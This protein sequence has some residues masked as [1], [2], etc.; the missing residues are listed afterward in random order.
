MKILNILSSIVLA[1]FIISC[2]GK[3]T[4]KALLGKQTPYEKYVQSLR[5]AKLHQ[6]GL[7][8]DWLLAGNKVLQDSL[9]L[10]IPFEET[11]YFQAEKPAAFSYNFKAREGESIRIAA[12]SKAREEVKLFLDLFEVEDGR[13]RKVKH[14]KSAD[15]IALQINYRVKEDLTYL[16]RLQP[17]LLRSGSY[18]ISIVSQP[19]LGF[20]VQG[21][22][23]SAIQSVWGDVRDNGARRHEGIDIFAPRG[24]PAIAATKGMVTRVDETPIG[25]KVVWLNDDLTNQH[26]YYAHLDTQLVQSGQQVVPGQVLGLVGNTGNAR[27]TVPHLHFGIYRSGRGAVDPYPFVYTP[28]QKIS[29][30]QISAAQLGQWARISKKD[31]NVRLSPD[32]N[33]SLLTSLNKHTAVQIIGGTSTWYRVL[34]PTGQSGY[35]LGANVESLQKPLNNLKITAATEI[36]TEPLPDGTPIN[37]VKAS[38]TVTVLANYNNYLLVKTADGTLGWLLAV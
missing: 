15:T 22:G 27:T 34:L 4:I 24:T 25:G 10:P 18:T 5:M 9:L 21:K 26:L 31:V 7:G 8:Q 1:V 6:S 16:V 2:S 32:K 23:N 12:H 33:G 30:L 38:S 14:L 3:P 28:T 13:P 29:P 11:G 37:Q 36:L 17:E 20:P 19:S 35:I